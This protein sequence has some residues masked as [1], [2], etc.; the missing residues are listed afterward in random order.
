MHTFVL[1]SYQNSVVHNEINCFN[2]ISFVFF[3]GPP[4]AAYGG[5]QAKGWIGAVAT[6]LYHS[7]SNARSLTHWLRLGIEPESSWIL[8]RFDTTEPLWELHAFSFLMSKKDWKE[9]E[10]WVIFPCPSPAGIGC[11]QLQEDNTAWARNNT[12]WARNDTTGFLG[13]PISRNAIA[14]SLSGKFWLKQRVP[15]LRAVRARA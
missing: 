4:P 8:V 3:L 5:S 7:H 15:P 11:W 9:K 12:T 14:F 13:C 2:F 1:C 10:F 6:S